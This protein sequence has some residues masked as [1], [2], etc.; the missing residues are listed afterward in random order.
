MVTVVSMVTVCPWL[1]CCVGPGL[2]IRVLCQKDAYL[3][4][5]FVSTNATL[6][7]LVNPEQWSGVC[8]QLRESERQVLVSLTGGHCLYATLLPIYSVG[9]QVHK[10]RAMLLLLIAKYTTA[11][12]SALLFDIVCR[13]TVGL[14]TM[15][16]PCRVKGLPL[17]GSTS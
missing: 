2:A 17:T 16:L 11:C 10:L 4:D 3:R 15:W 1:L 12:N 8:Q 7:S 9:V 13:E 14:I 6:S 5:N